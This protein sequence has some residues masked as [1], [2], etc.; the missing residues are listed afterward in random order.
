M[1]GAGSFARIGLLVVILQVLFCVFLA[2]C[3]DNEVVVYVSLDREF[4]APVL[5]QFEQETGIKVKPVY[6]DEATKTVGLV[7]RL[8]REHKSGRVQCDVFW[9]NETSRSLSLKKKGVSQSYKSPSAS[10]IPAD[11]RDPENHWTGFA[12]RARVLVYNTKLL[13]KED[14]PVSIFELTDAKWKDKV[15]IAQPTAGTTGSHVAALA[16]HMGKEKAL[17]Y[18]RKLAENGCRKYPGNSSVRDRVAQGEVLIGFTDTDDVAAGK[19]HGKSID[20]IFPDRDGMGTLVIPNT[21]VLMAGA[22]N[23]ENAKKFIDWLL[24]KETEAILA[25]AESRQIPLRPDVKVP[26]DGFT[27][28]DIKAMDVDVSRI[29]EALTEISKAVNRLL[30]K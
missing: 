30:T 7:N 1:S 21:V 16:V 6:D 22:P 19:L 2:G 15:A 26:S 4:S 13:K 14:L 24:R 5:A 17:E 20:M 23:T 8:V 18:F 28:G 25:A 12:A 10:D 29:S 9:N 3:T 11:F 27:L